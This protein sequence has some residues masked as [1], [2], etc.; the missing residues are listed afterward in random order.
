MDQLAPLPHPIDSGIAGG[1]GRQE[2]AHFWHCHRSAMHHQ[3]EPENTTYLTYLRCKISRASPVRPTLPGWAKGL[4]KER[5][6]RWYGENGWR[7]LRDAG[8]GSRRTVCGHSP[9][10]AKET[11]RNLDG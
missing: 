9:A 8:L 1:K 10:P 5:V 7:F 11:L 2:Q 4:H 6:N 3:P